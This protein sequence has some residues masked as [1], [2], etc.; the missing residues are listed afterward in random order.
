MPGQSCPQSCSFTE[1]APASVAPNVSSS[2]PPLPNH[3]IY[4]VKH[5]NTSSS[6]IFLA[7]CSWNLGLTGC[8]TCCACVEPFSLNSS[9]SF[10]QLLALTVMVLKRLSI[11]LRPGAGLVV[12]AS[13]VDMTFNQI[14]KPCLKEV[15][16]F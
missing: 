9:L 6:L 15:H 5:T 14:S 4:D 12:Y 2:V 13:S 10:C 3:I 8:K 16:V 7:S 11:T 1:R